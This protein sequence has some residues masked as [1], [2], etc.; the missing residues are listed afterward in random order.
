M[1]IL[2]VVPQLAS[3]ARGDRVTAERWG[4]IFR[5]LEHDAVFAHEYR[6]QS[7]DVLVALHAVR[8]AS[9][10]AAFA[11]QHGDLPLVVALTGTDIYP[12]AD[13]PGEGTAAAAARS[14]ES[15]TRLV[16]MQ[17]LALDE[18][19]A[20]WRDKAT[21]IFQSL[22]PADGVS[23]RNEAI[24][25][26][27]GFEVCVVGELC[28]IKDPFRAALAA[29]RLPG[30]SR[31]RVLQLGAA[32]KDSIAERS[33]K[34]EQSN[35]R[36]SWLGEVPRDEALSMIARCA[37]VVSS[38]LSEGS[39]NVLTEALALG[40]PILATRVPGNVGILGDDYPGLF[41]VQD[42][43]ALSELIGRAESESEFYEE[44]C[45]RCAGL[46][47]LTDL[48]RERQAWKELLGALGG[49]G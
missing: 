34:E 7:C 44:L 5:D 8:S 4:R 26:T 24:G 15:A 6:E 25:W 13:D 21:V 31:V 43:E 40:T 41:P 3:P 38:S 33:A 36:Y 14:M 30:D 11:A 49:T 18:I 45:Q 22:E 32:G 46:A 12:G 1:N 39:P 16:A 28:D 47:E 19:P 10:I 23:G 42:T 17:P 20:Q 2:I 27:R 48:Q 37:L 29:R 35:P 9:S